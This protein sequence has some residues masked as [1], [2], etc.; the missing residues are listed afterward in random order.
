MNSR[1]F[2]FTPTVESAEGVVDELKKKGIDDSDI[3]AIG[4]DSMSLE[5]LPEADI[6][7]RSDVVDA[8]KRG[9][10]TGGA[11]GLLG[12]IVAVT[13]PAATL[14]VGGGAVVAGT[15]LGSALGTWFST[16]IGVSVPNQDVEEYRSRL[17]RGEV[18]VIVDCNDT[19]YADVVAVIE[20]QGSRV[21]LHNDLE[22][23]AA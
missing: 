16:M 5:P 23:S 7:H 4:N 20:S 2:F 6:A 11:I 14:A 9:A 12:G 8:A 19:V 13:V 21:L 15:V 17:D 18:M 3:H 22:S 10:V 1:Y